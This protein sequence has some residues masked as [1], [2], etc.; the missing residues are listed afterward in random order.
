MDVVPEESEESTEAVDGVQLKLLAGGE[1]ANLQHFF[2]EPGA[3][4][5]EHSHPH[6]Q[7]GFVVQGTLTFVVDGEDRP[8]GEGDTYHLAGGEPHA[9]ENHGDVPVVG[10]DV[11]SPPR[12]DPDWRD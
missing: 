3:T 8:V 6:E 9:A 2:I 7:L 5:P 10:Y 1:N 12:D 4:V 11:F